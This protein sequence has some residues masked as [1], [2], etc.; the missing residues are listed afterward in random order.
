MKILLKIFLLIFCAFNFLF[1]QTFD[2]RQLPSEKKQ[3]EFR[4]IKPFI[5]NDGID[6][7]F[8]SGIYQLSA[9]IPIS[10]KLNIVGEIPFVYTKYEQSSFFFGNNEFEESG[11]ANIFIGLQTTP[12]SGNNK[13]SVISFGLYL[14]TAD[15]RVSYQGV[16]VDYYE[17][18]KYLPHTLGLYFNYAYHKSYTNGLRFGFEVGPNITIPTEGNRSGDL[19]LHYG[20]TGGFEIN[21]IFL[22]NIELAGVAIVT[23]SVDDFGDRFIH[24]MNFGAALTEGMFVPKIFYKIYLD[25]TFSNAISGSLGIGV[26]MSL[27]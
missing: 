5:K 13:K 15:E 24:L 8:L 7:S 10:S 4:F 21:K 11:F 23:E 17:F 27:D 1:A 25:D 22:L 18:Q 20:L 14:P 16:I 2:F 19:L 9:N 3:F 6:M 12:S 26:S